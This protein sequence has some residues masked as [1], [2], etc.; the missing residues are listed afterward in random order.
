M[1]DVVSSPQVVRFGTYEVHLRSGELRKNGIRVRLTGQPFQVLA[2]LLE[3]PGELVTREEL[4]KRLWPSDTF[5]DFD[6]GLNAA[7]NRV[8]EALADSAENPRFVETLPRRGYRFIGQVEASE[9]ITPVGSEQPTKDQR[10]RVSGRNRKI[11]IA[12]I[13]AILVIVVAFLF[14]SSARLASKNHGTPTRYENVNQLGTLTPVPFSVLPGK[15]SGP[16]FSPDGSHVAFAWDGDATPG[17]SGFDL[18]VKAIGSET[19]L[20]LTQHPS[21]CLDAAW[22]PDGTQIAFHR[23][24]G[25]SAGLYVVPALGGAERKLRS[26]HTPPSPTCVFNSISWSPD[27]K[28]IAFVDSLPT[29]EPFRIHLLSVEVL[30][31]KQIPPPAGCQGEFWPAYS[32]DGTQL[33]YV[34]LYGG[35]QFGMYSVSPS[36]GEPKLITKFSGWPQGIAWSADHKRL[37]VSL[38]RETDEISVADG[39]M[40]K[41]PLGESR[42][43]AVSRKG[44]EFTYVTT[45]ENVNIWRKDLLH[46][47]AAAVKLLSSTRQQTEPQYSP[48]GNHIAFMSDRTGNMEIWISDADGTHLVQVSNFKYPATG[49]PHWSPDGTRI[50]FDSRESGHGE[51]Y[52]VDISERIPHRLVTSLAENSVPSWSRDG[53]WIYFVSHEVEAVGQRIFRCP[54]GGGDA[55]DMMV[56]PANYSY[57]PIESHD[58][59]TVYFTASGIGTG[60]ILHTVSVN[61]P[62]TESVL[63]EMPPFYGTTLWDLV[64]GGIY[65]V[66]VD[67]PRSVRYFDFAAK[68]VRQVFEIDKDFFWGLSVS[69]NARWILYSQVDDLKS[70]V[71]LVDH[72][73]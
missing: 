27:G 50:A 43:P 52:L 65:F 4:Q 68:K 3:H 19:L 70:E 13:A 42:W 18:Y 12:S 39:S 57:G 24:S 33:A 5:V 34:C 66:P 61:D 25:S 22:S 6:R 28:W 54:A 15:Q 51:V 9:K 37:I 44:D 31:S 59:K 30:E 45:S 58:G 2:I 14:R 49:S 17:S 46:P 29:G 67:A 73:R 1:S 60:P 71:L 11:A 72:F 21:R 26:T 23:I 35:M 8:R 55:V 47:E 10:D 63:G 16:T 20:R 62:R 36:G 7:V 32:P 41:L 48:D 40:Q 69:P 53:K 56:R 64:P 38:P